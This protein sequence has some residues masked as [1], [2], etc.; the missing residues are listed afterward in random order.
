MKN[1]ALRASWRFPL[2]RTMTSRQPV[3]VLYHDT[4][5]APGHAA[6]DSE[7]FERH[8][9]FLVE[10][11]DLASTEDGRKSRRAVDRI[12]VLVT[13]DDGFRNNA[14]VAAPILRKYRVPALFF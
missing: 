9:R 12:Q 14:E 3:I 13:F 5:A 7:V 4:P 10:H 2:I 11:F 6:L 1:A 8:V